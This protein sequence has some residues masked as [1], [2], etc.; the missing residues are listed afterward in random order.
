MSASLAEG[1]RQ[2]D[3]MANPATT[4]AE[5]LVIFGITGDPAKGRP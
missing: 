4:A 2:G 3:E 5:V 1:I